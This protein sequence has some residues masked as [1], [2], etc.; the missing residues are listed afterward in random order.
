M[1]LFLFHDFFWNFRPECL[2]ALCNET[3]EV[4][5]F[6][7]IQYINVDMLK[8]TRLPNGKI[9]NLLIWFI[10]FLNRGSTKM[11]ISLKNSSYG[12]S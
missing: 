8:L 11:K 12:I 9:F 10:C 4:D 3:C 6:D 1:I 2:I 5:D 7:F